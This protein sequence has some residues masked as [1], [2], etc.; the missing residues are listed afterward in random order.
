MRRPSAQVLGLLGGLAVLRSVVLLE[1][2]GPG[3]TE[4]GACHAG[5]VRVVELDLRLDL[6][7]AD[8]VEQAEQASPTPTGSEGGEVDR[9]AHRAHAASAAGGSADELLE[10]V[11][12]RSEGAGWIGICQQFRVNVPG[13][14][15][16][17]GLATDEALE[18]RQDGGPPRS[19][20]DGTDP[21]EKAVP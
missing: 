10:R 18:D 9:G 4:V 15:Q 16:L 2:A 13:I 6:D 8:G 5:T 11:A 20:T 3:D 14:P 19:A 17:A 7:A 21:L 12:P 1:Q